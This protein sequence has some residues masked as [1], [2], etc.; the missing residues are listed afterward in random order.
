MTQKRCGPGAGNTEAR[1]AD[2]FDRQ[3]LNNPASR[4]Y[5]DLSD[6]Q[7]TK[8]RRLFYFS[9]ATAHAIARLAFSVPR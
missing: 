8:L 5:Q 2:C 1:E 3:S 6:F 7:A 9:Q 4:A